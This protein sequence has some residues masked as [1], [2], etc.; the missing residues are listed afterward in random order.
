MTF[1]EGKQAPEQVKLKELVSWTEH[2]D[3]GV[4]YFSGTAIYSSEF[5]YKKGTE[6]K[7]VFLNLGEV[8]NVA[9]VSLNGKNLGTL[10]KPPFRLEVGDVLKEGKNVIEIKIT[11]L[12]VNRLVGDEKL[13]P[14]PELDYLPYGNW[15][16]EWIAGGPLTSIPD[17]VKN[18]GKSPVG[19]TSFV[20]WKFYDGDDSKLLKSGLIGPVIITE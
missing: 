1:P 8:K 2:G 9:E 10:W 12:W 7:D 14:D 13:H 4:K 17:W 16:R 19:R 5:T 11:N 3:P 18:G 6:E 20:L 15:G